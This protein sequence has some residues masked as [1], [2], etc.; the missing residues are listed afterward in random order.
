MVF[1]IAGFIKNFAT[2]LYLYGQLKWLINWLLSVVNS[3]CSTPWAFSIIV[4][5]RVSIMVIT[6]GTFF[7]SVSRSNC[8]VANISY[9]PYPILTETQYNLV[10]YAVNISV[11][12]M[13]HVQ[14]REAM[15]IFKVVICEVAQYCLK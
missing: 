3:I 6:S 4:V 14:L 11:K 12:F 13:E 10:C 1:I 9:L 8:Y 15:Y 2:I 5:L 7:A